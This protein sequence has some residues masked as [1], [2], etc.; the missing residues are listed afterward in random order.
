MKKQIPLESKEKISSQGVEKSRSI[1]AEVLY[2]TVTGD[3]TILK[4]NAG[5]YLQRGWYLKEEMA[6]GKV[7]LRRKKRIQTI[8]S[9]DNVL[10]VTKINDITG[11]R[12]LLTQAEISRIAKKSKHSVGYDWMLDK[13]K[14]YIFTPKKHTL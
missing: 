2:N 8:I 9:E 10:Y 4:T 5:P 13:E 6:D 1:V 11:K 14:Q 12:L 3:L 7:I